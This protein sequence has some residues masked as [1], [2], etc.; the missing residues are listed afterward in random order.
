M[1]LLSLQYPKPLVSSAPLVAVPGDWEG[2][3]SCLSKWRAHCAST[4]QARYWSRHRISDAGSRNPSQ[5][6]SSLLTQHLGPRKSWV[7]LGESKMFRGDGASW[8]F[9]NSVSLGAWS[10]TRLLWFQPKRRQLRSAATLGEREINSPR[11][12]STSCSFRPGHTR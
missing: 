2:M 9:A 11:L 8:G 10:W 7:G 1:C 12:E 6:S 5:A 4:P 3:Q